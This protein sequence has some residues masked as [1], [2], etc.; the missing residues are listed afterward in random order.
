MSEM[1]KV[2]EF[3]AKQQHNKADEIEALAI[4]FLTFLEAK[5]AALQEDKAR[6]IDHA[7]QLLELIGN[8][9]PEPYKNHTCGAPNSHCDDHCQDIVSVARIINEAGAAIDAAKEKPE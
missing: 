3:R 4:V 2:L 6:L 7:E 8:G 5:V 9:I 1:I